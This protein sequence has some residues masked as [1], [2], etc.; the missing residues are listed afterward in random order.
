MKRYLR[1][2][3]VQRLIMKVAE[4]RGLKAG[5][6]VGRFA[7]TELSDYDWSL[8]QTTLTDKSRLPGE[9][10]IQT[11]IFRDTNVQCEIKYFIIKQVYH[12]QK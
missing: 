12:V 11:E 4:R 1:G 5:K 8:R 9:K 3:Y 2:A 7:G 6:Q 10:H